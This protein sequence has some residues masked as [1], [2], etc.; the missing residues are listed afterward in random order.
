[1]YLV[2]SWCYNLT[3][4]ILSRTFECEWYALQRDTQQ[5]EVRMGKIAITF[6]GSLVL[7]ASAMFS[8][9]ARAASVDEV[10]AACDKMADAK[11]GSCNY[12]TDDKGLGGC[13]RN[14]CFY[15][16]ADGSRQC[17]A[18]RVAGKSK[19]V[20]IAGIRLSCEKGDEG[21]CK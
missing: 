6:M 9:P 2:A 15:C 8:L 17:H 19:G 16:P 18:T 10:V 12:T 21:W 20:H 7:V 3:S 1:M 11:P 14:G 4:V 5:K 13:T